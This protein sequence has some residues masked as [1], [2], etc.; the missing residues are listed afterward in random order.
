ME[1]IAQSFDET[2]AD[3]MREANNEYFIASF[4]DDAEDALH[5]VREMLPKQRAT[6]KGDLERAAAFIALALKDCQ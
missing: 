5:I 1:N 6:I 4:T 3:T 2:K